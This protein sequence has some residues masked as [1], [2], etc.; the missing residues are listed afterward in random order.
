MKHEK[1]LSR[2]QSSRNF[3]VVVPVNTGGTA[4]LHLGKKFQDAK[5]DPAV[6]T[7]RFSVTLRFSM[8]SSTSPE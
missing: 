4:F 7:L 1:V 3:N 2:N 5:P 6:L 8:S